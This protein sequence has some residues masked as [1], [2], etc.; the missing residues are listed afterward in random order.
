MN[1]LEGFCGVC[2]VLV[3]NIHGIGLNET[4]GTMLIQFSNDT[5]L[6]TVEPAALKEKILICWR[7]HWEEN[8]VNVN[9]KKKKSGRNRS[10]STG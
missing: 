6:F 5:N 4:I 9:E 1:V 8:R 3:F 10:L 7:N 2:S